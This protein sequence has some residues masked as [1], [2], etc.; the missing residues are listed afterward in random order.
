MDGGSTR[1]PPDMK[2]VFGGGLWPLGWSVGFVE[3]PLSETYARYRAWGLGAAFNELGQLPIV[4]ALHQLLPFE[5]PY[6]RR[7]LVGTSGRWTT[8]SAWESD[9]AVRR[10]AE[11][12]PHRSIAP[13]ITSFSEVGFDLA[14]WTAVGR[15][16]PPRWDKAVGLK[17]K[18]PD[19]DN[20]SRRG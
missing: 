17:L 18:G 3:R 6:T 10:F 1:R 2:L 13:R 19:A 16:L 20:A 14:K 4:D 9:E 7:L 15:D 11:T 5:M 12:E 8:L